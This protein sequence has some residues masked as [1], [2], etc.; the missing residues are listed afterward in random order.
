MERLITLSVKADDAES[1]KSAFDLMCSTH[2]E[3]AEVHDYTSFSSQSLAGGEQDT[4]ICDDISHEDLFVDSNT[5]TKFIKVLRENGASYESIDKIVADLNDIGILL[6]ERV[7]R[8][9]GSDSVP[10]GS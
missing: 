2:A 1:W 8:D 7:P 9:N 10:S 6:R 5:L 4:P 3:L